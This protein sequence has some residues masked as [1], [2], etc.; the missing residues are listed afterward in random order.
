MPI[1]CY[2]DR[3]GKIHERNFSSAAPVPACIVLTGGSK[4]KRCFQAETKS[5]PP[6]KGWPLTCCASGVHASQAQEL[7][8]HLASK[9]V[10]TE[11]TRDGD[12][13]YRDA[14]HRRK[15]L[16]VRGMVDKSS[17]I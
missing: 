14:Q 3:N 6:T 4:A 13:V 17:F 11:V 8:D 15:A 12:P 10:P 1:Y 16:K 2:K 9:G 7:R 5:F